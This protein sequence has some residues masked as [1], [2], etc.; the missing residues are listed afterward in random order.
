MLAV[1]VTLS[2]VGLAGHEVWLQVTRSS[3]RGE[4]LRWQDGSVS[5]VPFFN[6]H[7]ADMTIAELFLALALVLVARVIGWVLAGFIGA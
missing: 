7:H 6:Y 2:A 3:L 4:K 1:P 5:I